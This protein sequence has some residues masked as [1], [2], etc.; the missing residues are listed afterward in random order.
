MVANAYQLTRKLFEH[1][2]KTNYMRC[3][4]FTVLLFSALFAQAQSEG[5][6]RSKQSGNW[7]DAGSWQRHNGTAF[8]DAADASSATSR[9]IGRSNINI[10]IIACFKL[11]VMAAQN[12]LGLDT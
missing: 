6:Y 1:S 10:D 8:V 3:I 9:T 11:K 5:D 2:L 4:I 7:S 12:A